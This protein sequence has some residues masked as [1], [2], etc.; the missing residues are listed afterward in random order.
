VEEKYLVLKR[1]IYEECRVQCVDDGCIPN[2]HPEQEETVLPVVS[3]GLYDKIR[4]KL[5]PYHKSLFYFGLKMLCVLV[6][7]FAIFKLINMLHEFNITGFVQVVTTGS[8][9][10]IPHVFNVVALKTNDEKKEAWEEKLKL[11]VKYMVKYLVRENSELARTVLIMQK[12]NTGTNENVQNRSDNHRENA[13]DYE[14]LEIR[15]T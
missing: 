15:S 4:E 14:L 5:L 9:G 12:N 2:R 11:N 7:S 8:L 3:K 13:S 1:L 6:F 10:V